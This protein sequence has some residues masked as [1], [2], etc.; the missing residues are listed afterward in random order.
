MAAPGVTGRRTGVTGRHIVAALVAVALAML[1]VIA[2]AAFLVEVLRTTELPMASTVSVEDVTGKAF[3]AGLACWVATI[4]GFLVLSRATRGAGVGV[5]SLVT[6]AA[7]SGV[8]VGINGGRIQGLVFPP[9]SLADGIDWDG[10]L[11]TPVVEEILKGLAVVA[12]M[13][14]M[15]TAGARSPRSGILLGAAAGLG[16]TAFETAHFIVAYYLLQSNAW[17]GTVIALRFAVVGLGMHATASAFTGLG[18]GAWLGRG[19]LRRDAWMPLAGLAAA[20]AL[21]ALW[22]AVASDLIIE[23]HRRL[24][25]PGQVQQPVESFIAASLVSVLLLA[26]PWIV[27]AIA[28]RRGGTRPLRGHPVVDA[29]SAFT[30]PGEPS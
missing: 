1:V 13:A 20:V 12:A 16:M 7:V 14:V 21:H 4:P 15:V 26:G 8:L 2:D 27:L 11:L 25:P 19:S 29:P 30:E 23:L 22:N 24:G 18:L 5:L 17:F 28:W 10:L 6:V 9:F 3:F